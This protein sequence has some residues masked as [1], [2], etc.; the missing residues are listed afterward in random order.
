MRNH[1]DTCKIFVKFFS[2]FQSIKDLFRNN[3]FTK[4]EKKSRFRDFDNDKMIRIANEMCLNIQ[5]TTIIIQHVLITRMINCCTIEDVTFFN[6]NINENVIDKK[7]SFDTSKT[8][9]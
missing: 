4:N 9:T 7:S 1:F 3:M 5:M 2:L 6:E 8:M